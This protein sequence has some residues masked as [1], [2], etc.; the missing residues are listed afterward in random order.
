MNLPEQ[1]LR[2]LLANRWWQHLDATSEAAIAA[3]PDSSLAIA[4]KGFVCLRDGKLDDARALF[5]ASLAIDATD[6]IARTGL[7]NLHYQ[8]ANFEEADEVIMGL[9]HDFPNEAGLHA[10]RCRLYSIFASHERTDQ[11]IRKSLHLNPHDEE[12]RAIEL[13]HAY[14]GE[15]ETVQIEL[16]LKLLQL[17]PQN[18][19]A[20]TILGRARLKERD[21]QSAEH[22]LNTCM[23]IAPS[24][25]TAR[26]VQI[27]EAAR[28]G[29]GSW[30]LA[31]WAYR[32]KIL[33]FLFPKHYLKKRVKLRWDR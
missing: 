25:D 12:L 9:L 29:R 19:L 11:M 3:E 14:Q 6:V 17:A 26:M 1:Q 30:R 18:L 16:S 33:K 24:E 23:A 22:H 8:D 15:G 28:S 32:R 13:Y 20:H 4:A 2:V 5:H 31:A 7:F 21:F 27:L 10:A